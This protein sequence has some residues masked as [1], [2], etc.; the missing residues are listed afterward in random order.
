MARGL[1]VHSLEPQNFP[2]PA[3]MLRGKPPGAYTALKVD[4]WRHLVDWTL[5]SRRLAKSVQV[6]HEEAGGMYKALLSQVE[7]QGTTLNRCI[8]HALLP[9]LVL[10]L[11]TCQEANEQKTSYCMLVPL[12]CDPIGTSTQT[13][14][15]LDVFVLAEPLSVEASHPVEVS[16]LGRPRTIPLA[17][18][19]QWATDRQCIE[20]KKAKSDGEALLCTQDGNL[21]EGLLTNFFVVQ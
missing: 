5:H 6:L 15:P 9:S 3:D 11:Q 17:K 2:G 12:L 21:L 18:F 10:A 1:A 8:N 20:A 7:T 16:V 19:S 4:N 14:S 13:G